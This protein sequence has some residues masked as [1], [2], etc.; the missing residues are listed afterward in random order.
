M[1]WDNTDEHWLDDFWKGYAQPPSYM[2]S[3]TP[4]HSLLMMRH[5]NKRP[6]CSIRRFTLRWLSVD[7]LSFDRA[8]HIPVSARTPGFRAVACYDGTEISALSA[9]ELL[10]AYST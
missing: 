9:F 3:L 4:F 6:P 7:E 5:A 1:D 10:K 2:Q 8:K